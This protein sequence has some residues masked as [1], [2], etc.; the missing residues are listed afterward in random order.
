MAGIK[1]LAFIAAVGFLFGQDYVEG[2]KKES[3]SG[4]QIHGFTLSCVGLNFRNGF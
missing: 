2:E 1:L 3:R 4:E